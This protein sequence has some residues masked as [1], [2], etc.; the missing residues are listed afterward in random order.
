MVDEKNLA[1]VWRTEL[2][3]PDDF[4]HGHMCGGK[5]FKKRLKSECKE[6]NEGPSSYNCYLT[7]DEYVLEIF[8]E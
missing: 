7:K 2:K 6:C 5:I 1:D 8:K 4:V 3:N